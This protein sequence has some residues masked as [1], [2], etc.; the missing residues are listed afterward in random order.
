MDS[1]GI[2]FGMCA[3]VPPSVRSKISGNMSHGGEWV[4]RILLMAEADELRG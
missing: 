3:S 2:W 1:I 4:Q